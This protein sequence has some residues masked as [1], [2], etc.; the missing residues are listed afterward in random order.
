MD[1]SNSYRDLVAWQQAMEL[2]YRVYDLSARFPDH[3]KFGLTSQMR[4][5][6]VSVPSNIAE[7]QGGN[8]KGEFLQFLGHAKG[9]L[10]ELETQLLIAGNLR[11]LDG[12]ASSDVF[13]QCSRVSKLLNGLLQSLRSQNVS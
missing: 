1:K 5:S 10:H 11:Y 13:D 6:A 3:E 8:S 7:G 2:V 4:R 12:D 9:S